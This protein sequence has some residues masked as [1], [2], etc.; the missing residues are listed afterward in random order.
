MKFVVDIGRG[1]RSEAADNPAADWRSNVTG[2]SA[3]FELLLLLRGLGRAASGV[4]AEQNAREQY[5]RQQK[6]TDGSAEGEM[7]HGSSFGGIDDPEI[8][9]VAKENTLS[10]RQEYKQKSHPESGWR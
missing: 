3:G 5:G 7:R 10:K 1:Y 2:C 8:G 6:L 4:A 9:I